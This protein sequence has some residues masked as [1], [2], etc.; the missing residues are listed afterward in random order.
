MGLAAVLIRK[1]N[2]NSVV[3]Y[4]LNLLN[5]SSAADNTEVIHKGFIGLAVSQ[6]GLSSL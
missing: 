4:T 2:G 3:Y 5:G 1:S 6:R